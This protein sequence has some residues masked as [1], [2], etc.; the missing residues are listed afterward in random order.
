[1][2]EVKLARYYAERAPDYESI[3]AKPERQA[4]LREIRRIIKKEFAGKHVLEVAC[5]TGYWTEALA[6]SVASVYATDI[7]EEVLEV[8][9]AKPAISKNPKVSFV[10]SDAYTLNGVPRSSACLI[11]FWWSHVPRER[12][13][14][15]LDVVHSKL[16]RSATVMVIDN[17]YVPASST[18]ISRRDDQGNTYQ[19]RMLANG[20]K[21]EVLKNFPS[22]SELKTAVAK[23]TDSPTVEL[24]EYYWILRYDV[25]KH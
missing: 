19:M 6:K 14:S 20:S 1:M 12:L 11:A 15:F 8:A 4:D 7:N 18:S 21:Y 22:E 10:Q 24:L 17:R 16:E 13:I 23:F 2:S 9:R 5:G 25:R 3:Y